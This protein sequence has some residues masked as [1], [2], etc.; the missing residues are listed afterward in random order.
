MPN[1][2]CRTKSWMH[3]RGEKRRTLFRR[4]PATCSRVEREV[5]ASPGSAL[6]EVCSRAACLGDRRGGGIGAPHAR[7]FRGRPAT[8]HPLSR[9]F[10]WLVRRRRSYAM[11]AWN[12]SAAVAGACLVRRVGLRV[13]SEFAWVR[14]GGRR[15]KHRPP[16]TYTHA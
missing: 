6:P 1:Q 13:H 14:L 7:P 8:A 16:Q 10:M 3:A 5:L 4:R 15:V 12:L 11:G 2:I 9:F